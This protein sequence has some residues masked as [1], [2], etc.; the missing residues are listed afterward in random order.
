LSAP[1]PLHQIVTYP[2][3]LAPRAALAPLQRAVFA[4]FVATG[5]FTVILGPVLPAFRL[6]WALSDSQAGFFFAAQFTGSLLGVGAYGLL[7]GRLGWCATLVAG[8]T[9][10]A[11]GVAFLGA[12]ELHFAWFGIFAAGFGNG[13]VTP[14]SNLIVAEVD[15][16][17]RASMLNL[18]NLCWGI[19]AISSPFF[20][21][22]AESLHQLSAF[23]WVFSFVLAACAVFFALLKGASGPI[24][25]LRRVSNAAP[26]RGSW[27]QSEGL[28]IPLTVFAA[29]FFLY[30][31]TE[32]SFGGWAASFA[33]EM[34]GWARGRSALMP[35]VFWAT[36]L[37]GRAMAPRLLGVLSETRMVFGGLGLALV[38]ASILLIA[39]NTT[40]VATAMALAGLGCSTIF[41][42]F[43]AWLT[44]FV[45]DSEEGLRSLPFAAA[46]IGGAVVPW[47]LGF[48]ATRFGGLR[49]AFILVTLTIVAM[50]LLTVLLRHRAV[51]PRTTV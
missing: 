28:F 45:D 36:L 12:S 19:G 24:A 42:I 6:Q 22:F 18:L 14:A 9:M 20:V 51:S 35:S 37:L 16:A 34:T 31:G 49:P 8:F 25:N 40:F 7:R 17:S 27:L 44:F 23:L 5:I 15:L 47:F 10:L 2:D 26:H 29:L 41:P 39:K 11:L 50:I 46:N 32:T 33:Q 3:T 38:S 4:G 43:I 48:L 13:L 30:V 1:A 21:T